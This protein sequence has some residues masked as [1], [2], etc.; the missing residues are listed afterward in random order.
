MKSQFSRRFGRRTTYVIDRAN[1][2]AAALATAAAHLQNSQPPPTLIEIARWQLN[3][4]QIAYERLISRRKKAR[5]RV[6][7]R[8]LAG[9]F[10]ASVWI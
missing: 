8:C 6:R 5:M 10:K 4:Q 3:A 2:D 1:V 9:A 7:G